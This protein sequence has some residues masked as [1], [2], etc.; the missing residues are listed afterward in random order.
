MNNV[1]QYGTRCSGSYIVDINSGNFDREKF[2]EGYILNLNSTVT[3]V[4]DKGRLVVGY[5]IALPDGDTKLALVGEIKINML[6]FG[7]VTG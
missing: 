6:G 1:F 7:K 3:F 4:D 5:V 2:D